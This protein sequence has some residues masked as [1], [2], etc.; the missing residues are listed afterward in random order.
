MEEI[1][2]QLIEKLNQVLS[3]HHKIATGKS[4]KVIKSSAKIISKKFSKEIKR[5]GDD[6]AN[7]KTTGTKAAA[8][9]SGRKK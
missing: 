3:N 7:G 5:L 4:K 9:T 6:K 1:Q 8:A 2:K